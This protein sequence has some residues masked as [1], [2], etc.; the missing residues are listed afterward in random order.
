MHSIPMPIQL[1]QMAMFE[2]VAFKHSP[3]PTRGETP[4]QDQEVPQVLPVDS[5]T[6]ARSER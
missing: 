1:F 5:E 3:D 6:A 2:G 4:P